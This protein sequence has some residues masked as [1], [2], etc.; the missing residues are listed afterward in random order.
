MENVK[1]D[2]TTKF[3][4]DIII[5]AGLTGLA[6]AIELQRSNCYVLVLEK[7]KYARLL[8]VIPLRTMGFGNCPIKILL[9]T[10]TEKYLSTVNK[11]LN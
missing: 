10:K 1:T 4:Y 7:N 3:Y 5:G 11:K 6:C 8:K 2:L 9:Y